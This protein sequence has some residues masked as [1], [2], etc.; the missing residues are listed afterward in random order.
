MLDAIISVEHEK[1]VDQNLILL[2]LNTIQCVEHEK[3]VDQKLILL[4]TL[5]AYSYL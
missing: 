4:A 1:L 5:L 2:M 3:V